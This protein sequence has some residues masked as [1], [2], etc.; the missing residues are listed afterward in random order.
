MVHFF[1]LKYEGQKN[2]KKMLKKFLRTCAKYGKNC[3]GISEYR[4]TMTKLQKKKKMLE[5]NYY[6]DKRSF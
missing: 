4:E 2:F 1:F 6:C 5:N 3:Y